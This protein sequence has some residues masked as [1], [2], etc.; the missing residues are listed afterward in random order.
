LKEPNL[1]HEQAHGLLGAP[2]SYIPGGFRG[3]MAAGASTVQVFTE[4]RE[5][6]R[7]TKTSPADVIQLSGC[8]NYQTS[9]DATERVNS[10]LF[11]LTER[12]KP[13]GL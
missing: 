13:W 5:N 1:L 10:R 4:V 8:K 6:I 7:Q 12:A 2:T 3:G 11:L 9:A